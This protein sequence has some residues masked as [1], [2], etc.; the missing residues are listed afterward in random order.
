MTPALLL[1]T[2]AVI[3]IANK[4]PIAESVL[5][6]IDRAQTGERSIFVSP[7]SAWEIGMLVSRGRMSLSTTPERWFESLLQAPGIRLLSL[8]PRILI[9]ASYLPGA[10]PSDPADRI[11]AAT[12]REFSCTLVTRDR[13]LLDYADQG[14]LKAHAC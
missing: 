8:P 10:P 12:A 2:C 14:H 5:A 7:V 11:F 1:D 13:S 6:E 4:E 3:W 9:A